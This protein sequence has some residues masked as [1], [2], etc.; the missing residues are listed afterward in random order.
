MFFPPAEP[1]GEAAVFFPSA[2][3]AA[4]TPVTPVRRA[5]VGLRATPP[6]KFK[7]MPSRQWESDA[8][9]CRVCQ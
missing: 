8:E 1:A 3:L 7:A 2:E 9:G 4:V 6:S 5:P